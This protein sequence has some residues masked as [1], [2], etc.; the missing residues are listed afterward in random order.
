M[1]GRSH[2]ALLRGPFSTWTLQSCQE[3]TQLYKSDEVDVRI[4]RSGSVNRDYPGEKLL[5]SP[6]CRSG[7]WAVTAGFVLVVCCHS[8]IGFT[9]CSDRATLMLQLASPVT[10]ASGPLRAA[11]TPLGGFMS[12]DLQS[13]S[14][15]QDK[16]MPG[17]ISVN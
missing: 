2:R 12:T 15:S 3:Q 13:C 11:P 17:A 4:V 10:S 1:P 8:D 5:R 9:R 6:A 14:K 7:P 16:T